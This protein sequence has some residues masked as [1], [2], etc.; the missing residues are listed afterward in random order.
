MRILIQ[1]S[2]IKKAKLILEANGGEFITYHAVLDPRLNIRFACTKKPFPMKG[3]VELRR[4]VKFTDKGERI[5]DEF[6]YIESWKDSDT[7]K[8]NPE[9]WSAYLQVEESAFDRLLKRIHL[10]LPAVT[11]MFDLL[12]EVITYDPCSP[13]WGDMYFSIEKR[14]YEKITEATLI[15]EPFSAELS[16]AS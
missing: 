6:R 12:S 10:G 15:Q 3:F 7:G 11:L 13:S 9:K 14:H 1:P 5:I 2:E 8:T 16:G 4:G